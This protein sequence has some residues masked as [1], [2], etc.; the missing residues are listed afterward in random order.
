MNVPFQNS[1]VK[2]FV[3]F[4]E[5]IERVFFLIGSS[6]FTIKK[7]LLSIGVCLHAYLCTPY[8][9]CPWALDSR[10]L[11]LQMVMSLHWVLGI[12]PRSSGAVSALNH[13]V[14]SPAPPC[15][16]SYSYSAFPF[17]E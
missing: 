2:Y 8:D 12:K 11:E 9:W 13:L 14:I 15:P 3:N 17:I 16:H 5:P 4:W 6:I 10:E 7:N 1:N